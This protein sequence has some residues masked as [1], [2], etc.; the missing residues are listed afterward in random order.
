MSGLKSIDTPDAGTVVVTFSAPNSA[1]LPIVAASYLG[2]IN[3]DVATPTGASA[4]ADAAT[5]DKAADWFLG[6]SAGSGPFK[7]ES[8]TQGDKLVLARNDAY[9]GPNKPVFPKVTIAQVKDSSSQLQQLQAG[10][11]RHRH[12]DL[13][14]FGRTASGRL[15]RDH[16][17]RRFLQLRLPRARVPAPRA[18]RISR[19]SR[20]ARRSSRPSTT[21]VRSSLRLQARARRSRRRS[22]TASPARPICRC[23]STISKEPS[24]CSPTPGLADVSI[25]TPPIPTL[26][27]YGVDFNLPMQKVQQDLVKIRS[28]SS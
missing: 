4:A 23:P 7:L 12:A 16:L 5:A 22:R 24:S 21:R 19:T 26:N 25:S 14:R 10:R 17:G 15:E 2:I 8:Y 18:R 9:W 1:F 3:S 11:R 20:S 27:V 28:T 13:A 6:H